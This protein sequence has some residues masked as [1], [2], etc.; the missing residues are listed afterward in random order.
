MEELVI[1]LKKALANTFAFYLKAHNYHW[2]ITGPNFPQYHKLLEG[3]YEEVYGS[4]DQFGEE[5]RALGDYAPGSFT[6]F[7]QLADIED[8]TMVPSAE[9]MLEKLGS[10]NQKVLVSI[11]TAYQLAEAAHKHGLSNFLAERQDAHSK[12]A[13]MISATTKR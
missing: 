1:A 13:W 12:H 11:E 9:A 2:N 4:V 6:R 10:D 8:E 3:I 5:I 7:A